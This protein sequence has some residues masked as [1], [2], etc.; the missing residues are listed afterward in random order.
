MNRAGERKKNFMLL[1][2]YEEK[3]FVPSDATQ[4]SQLVRLGAQVLLE[5]ICHISNNRRH[6]FTTRFCHGRGAKGLGFECVP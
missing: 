3:E 2:S 5:N 4:T 1:A 6:C